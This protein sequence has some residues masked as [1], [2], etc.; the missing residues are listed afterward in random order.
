M[1]RLTV[2]LFAGV[3]A[4]CGGQDSG[5]GTDLPS[6]DAAKE[7]AAEAGAALDD[8][9]SEAAASAG[10]EMEELAA[11]DVGD[12]QSASCLTLVA[13]GEF[14][15]AIPV[16]TAALAANPANQQ[17]QEALE[18][19]RTEG[20]QLADSAAAATGAAQQG[21]QEAASDAAADAVG[22]VLGN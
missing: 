20:G 22:N 12:G 17:V 13:E 4:A 7:A 5:S 1:K 18:T 15:Q 8:A 19:A 14:T 21:A 10:A 9:A 11:T 6:I 3:L 16:C 2:I